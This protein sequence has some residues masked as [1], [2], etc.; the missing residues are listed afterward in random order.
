[1]AKPSK[2]ERQKRQQAKQRRA[3]QRQQAAKRATRQAVRGYGARSSPQAAATKVSRSNRVASLSKAMR[4]ADP[5]LKESQAK[6]LAR[7]ALREQEQIG[8]D[9]K[10]AQAAAAF[11]RGVKGTSAQQG[12]RELGNAI[13]TARNKR[14]ASNTTIE[15]AISQAFSGSLDDQGSS[16]LSS[17][18]TGIDAAGV[19]DAATNWVLASAFMKYH[20]DILHNSR[21]ED[22]MRNIMD[23]HGTDDLATAFRETM[24]DIDQNL[25]QGMIY[26]TRYAYDHGIDYPD[27]DYD[28]AMV[29]EN[30]PYRG[31]T[32]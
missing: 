18:F 11:S 22:F 23:A 7:V 16:S 31:Y 10:I 30:S 1:M 29:Y 8:R 21:P 5:S 27:V 20:A 25:L 19:N 26:R 15:A 24:E 28:M 32:Q 6:R 13:D 2:A 12:M 4:D 3:K 9:R 14:D 17:L